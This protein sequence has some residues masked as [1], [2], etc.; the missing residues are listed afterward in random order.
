MANIDSVIDTYTDRLIDEMYSPQ[1]IECSQ[2]GEM[3]SDECV[4]QSLLDSEYNFCSEECV[5]L[6]EQKNKHDYEEDE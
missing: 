5:L 1:M 6:W 2:C 3:F 4:Y